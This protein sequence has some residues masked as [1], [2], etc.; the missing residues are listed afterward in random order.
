[1]LIN[2]F[3]YNNNKNISIKLLSFKPNYNYYFSIFY[4]KK[5]KFYLSLY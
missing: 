4:N 1:M 2:K 5:V 3:E